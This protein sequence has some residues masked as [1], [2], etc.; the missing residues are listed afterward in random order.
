MQVTMSLRIQ[1]SAK[2]FSVH[3]S[4]GMLWTSE[5]LIVYSVYTFNCILA[6]CQYLNLNIQ[7]KFIFYVKLNM[8]IRMM[9]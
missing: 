7:F 4:W 3:L 8:E 5:E 9:S 2:Y 6:T 1:G